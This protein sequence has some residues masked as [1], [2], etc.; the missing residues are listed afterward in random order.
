MTPDTASH[1]DPELVRKPHT[2]RGGKEFD[3]I[4]PPPRQRVDARPAEASDIPALLRHAERAMGVSLASETSVARILRAHL[5]SLWS[6]WTAG[7]LVGGFA[8]LMLNAHGLEDLMQDR[9]DLANPPVDVLAPPGQRPAAIYVWAVLGAAAASEGIARVIFR[10]RQHPYERSDVFALPATG[11][12]LRFMR[13]L[14]F[15]PVPGHRRSLH[16]YV[17]FANRVQ[18]SGVRHEWVKA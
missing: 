4:T 13:G 2:S 14:G 18:S 16:R 1:A 10:L 6:F 11:D 5:D 12:G 3:R 8:M 7:R 15:R 17:R 9:I